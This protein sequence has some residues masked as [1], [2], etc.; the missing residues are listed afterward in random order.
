MQGKL[1]CWLKK[2]R[3]GLGTALEK[4]VE[5][6]R[7]VEICALHLLPSAHLLT[8]GCMADSAKF[9]CLAEMESAGVG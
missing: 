5:G 9:S 2:V 6:V 1:K 7:R 3:G 4:A 8:T